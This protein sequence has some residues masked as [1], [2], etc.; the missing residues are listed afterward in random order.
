MEAY[1]D[2]IT[3][4]TENFEVTL[5]AKLTREEVKECL[6]GNICRCTSYQNIVDA[7]KLAAE[8]MRT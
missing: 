4:L 1:I 6:G 7:V 3:P 5:I 2:N 8:N